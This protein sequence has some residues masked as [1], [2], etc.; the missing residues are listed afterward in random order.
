MFGRRCCRRCLGFRR[1]RR[2][3]RELPC[4]FLR[5]TLLSQFEQLTNDSVADRQTADAFD[6]VVCRTLQIQFSVAPTRHL[7]RG[8]FEQFGRRRRAFHAIER[9]HLAPTVEGQRVRRFRI[10]SIRTQA[11]RQNAGRLRTFGNQAGDAFVALASVN[12]IEADLRGLVGQEQIER[13]AT[14][15]QVSRRPCRSDRSIGVI[16]LRRALLLFQN[17]VRV[18]QNRLPATEF[19]PAAL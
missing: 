15:N 9:K 10:R 8:R 13:Q 17:R 5:E 18:E 4:F 12:H 1:R 19:T 16:F 6:V 11:H 2:L 3:R 14:E 7:R